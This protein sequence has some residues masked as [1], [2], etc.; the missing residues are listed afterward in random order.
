[1]RVWAKAVGIL[2]AAPTAAGVPD[3]GPMMPRKLPAATV[4]VVDLASLE[5]PFIT[6]SSEV[7]DPTAVAIPLQASEIASV[8]VP[9]ATSLTIEHALSTQESIIAKPAQQTTCSLAAP[10]SI[11]HCSK[12]K[13][14]RVT[15]RCSHQIIGAKAEFSSTKLERR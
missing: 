5:T 13:P 4:D 15:P 10:T 11:K 6:T 14:A 8:A 7:L 1:V 3:R 12:M 2:A 9:Q